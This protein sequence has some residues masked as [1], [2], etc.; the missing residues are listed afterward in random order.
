VKGGELYDFIVE[1]EFDENEARDVVLQLL[2]AIEYLH[3]NGIAHRDLKPENILCADFTNSGR[4]RLTV[5]VAGESFFFSFSS[6]LLIF[7]FFFF[8]VQISL[9]DLKSRCGS[10]T[11]IAPEVIESKT[12]YNEAVDMWA[13]G[14]I[15]FV[16]LTGCFPFFE[17][18]NDYVALYKKISSVDYSFPE[19]PEVSKQARD[20]IEHLLVKDVRTR[21]T[22]EQCRNHPWLKDY[23]P[24]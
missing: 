9:D 8:G 18:S 21:F 17:E 7:S 4:R 14:V 6:F 10:P 12:T 3:A 15:T 23:K 13:L 19:E 2:S 16:L 24:A 20:F 1:K 22:P 5:K 11:Y